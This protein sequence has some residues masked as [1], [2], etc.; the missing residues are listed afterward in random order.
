MIEIDGHSRLASVSGQVRFRELEAALGD[1]GLTLGLLRD[2]DAHV[3]QR[4]L[5]G[6]AVDRSPRYGRLADA[7]IGLELSNEAGKTYE[8]R[9]VPRRATGP[10]WRALLASMPRVRV[11]RAVLR[12]HGRPESRLDF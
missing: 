11:A 4:L 12:V 1:A 8:L 9:S 5:Q 3:G 10:D 6:F 2:S 7:C